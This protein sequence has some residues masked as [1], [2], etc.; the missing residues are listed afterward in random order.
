[1]HRVVVIIA[2]LVCV[3][4]GCGVFKSSTS[5]ASSE[6]SSDS[7]S[8]SSS[9][10]D[11][12]KKVALQRDVQTLVAAHATRSGDVGALRRDLSAV[13]EAHGLTDWERSD[14]V[15]VAIGRGLAQAGVGRARAEA[16]GRD[17]GQANQRSAALVAAG[18][19]K[20]AAR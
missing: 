17:L 16:V 19:G 8:S 20:T 13:A 18:Y 14:D 10:D 1:M 3:G 7:S 12:E 4:T 11:E 5:Q 6:S 2:T 15:Y 9:K